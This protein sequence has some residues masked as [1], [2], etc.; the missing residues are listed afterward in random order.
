MG[1]ID[2]KAVIRTSKDI[3]ARTEERAVDMNLVLPDYYPPIAAILKCMLIPCISSRF[4]SGDQY[5]VDGTSTIRLLYLSDDRDEVYCF[6]AAQPFHVNF[7]CEQAIHHYTNVKADYVNCRAVAPRR[8]DVHGAFRVLFEG[9]GVCEHTVFADPQESHLYCFVQPVRYTVP[10]CEAEKTISVEEAVDLGVRVDRMLY[11]RA[12]VLSS[13]CKVL[14]NKIIA[15]GVLRVKTVCV[16]DGAFHTMNHDIPFSQ[17][18]DVDGLREEWL[19]AVEVM[20]GDNE[21]YLQQNEGGG[22]LL[23]VNCK[24]IICARLTAEKEEQLVLD[25]YHTDHPALCE[26]IPLS[27]EHIG[28]PTMWRT[29]VSQAVPCPESASVFSDVWGDIRSWEMRDDSE[30][31]ALNLCLTICMIAEGE[32]GHPVYYERTADVTCVPDVQGKPSDVQLVGVSV[33]ESGGTL[34]VQADIV[35]TLCEHTCQSHAVVCSVVCDDSE[36]Y[37]RSGAALRIVYAKEG[38]SLWDIG[39]QHHASV[40]AIKQDNPS[41]EAILSKPTMLMIP[42]V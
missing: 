12:I 25:A 22:A 15:K 18:M 42:L 35:V 6:E 23:F 2:S 10:V 19:C 34:H 11:S 31:S 40:E 27:V 21:S 32:D 8:V 3:A 36:C 14:T 7:S 33:R 28:A 9:V 1:T 13:E 37:E 24:L 17:I 38:Q 39:K 20:T 4:Q 41:V 5:S 26:T 16:Q 30:K 29:T